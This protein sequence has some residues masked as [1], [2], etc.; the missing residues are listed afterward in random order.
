VAGEQPNKLFEA[1]AW[2]N[3]D[4]TCFS[5]VNG[6]LKTI[7][8]K[9]IEMARI[10][11]NQ[12]LKDLHPGTVISFDGSW[13]H[14]RNGGKC[15]VSVF[16]QRTHKVVDYIVIERADCPISQNMEVAGLKIMFERL[17]NC[18]AISGYVHDKDAK[19]TKAIRDLKWNIEEYLDPSHS[20]KSFQ[21]QLN[22]HKTTFSPKIQES[23]RKMMQNILNMKA[24]TEQKT[25]YWLNC[26]KHFL[27]DH[28]GCP[29]PHSNPSPVW[30]QLAESAVLQNELNG[31]LEKTKKIIQMCDPRYSTQVNES[32]NRSKLKYATK[33]VKWK[34]TWA[35]RIACAV[36]DRN[37]PHWKLT[38]YDSLGLGTLDHGA[39]A[40]LRRIEDKRLMQK[41]LRSSEAWNAYR[42]SERRKLKAKPKVGQPA[43]ELGY[44]PNPYHEEPIPKPLKAYMKMI[45]NP[46]LQRQRETITP[47]MITEAAPVVDLLNSFDHYK[48]GKQ[49]SVRELVRFVQDQTPDITPAKFL[50]TIQKNEPA[51]LYERNPRKVP[52]ELEMSTELHRRNKSREKVFGPDE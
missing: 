42:R 12:E 44:K 22:K 27:G 31:F 11:C 15:C 6:H 46:G 1:L 29:K 48:R 37:L 20:V 8:D 51:T 16:S 30:Q 47:Q 36:L 45:V 14:R 17:R 25:G 49:L 50:A 52:P 38:L 24:T 7:G 28:L 3:C 21:R 34:F 41:F 13:D 33:D 35:A 39:R 5:E 2:N 32:F 26:T 18:L 4:P 9:I 40:Y 23:L 43:G 19:A 10:S